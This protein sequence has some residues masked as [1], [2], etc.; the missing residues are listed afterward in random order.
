MNSQ[1]S[2]SESSFAKSNW[3][4]IENDVKSKLINFLQSNEES[5]TLDINNKK[6]KKERESMDEVAF[7]EYK[8]NFEAKMKVPTTPHKKELKNRSLALI[9]YI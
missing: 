4:K 9:E 2:I 7:L 1:D 8:R 5:I 3:Q 6:K